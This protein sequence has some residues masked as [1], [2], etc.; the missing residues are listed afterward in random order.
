MTWKLNANNNNYFET[1]NLNKID[2]IEQKQDNLNVGIEKNIKFLQDHSMAFRLY[3]HKY[4]AEYLSW[5]QHKSFKF[6]KHVLA[7]L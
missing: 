7:C 5:E 6:T 3:S 2:S 4:F 1:K